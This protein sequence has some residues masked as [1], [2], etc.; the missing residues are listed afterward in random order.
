MPLPCEVLSDP[1][2]NV[3]VLVLSPGFE[4][5]R[6]AA[7]QACGVVLVWPGRGLVHELH[8]LQ[9]SVVYADPNESDHHDE[10]TLSLSCIVHALRVGVLR[11]VQLP[12]H[13]HEVGDKP[14]DVRYS[15]PNLVETPLPDRLAEDI[16]HP[17]YREGPEYHARVVVRLH[18]R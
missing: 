6:E 17:R 18:P 1:Q 5:P 14:K 9:Y 15:R 7:L 13:P 12:N 11:V 3:E 8:G 2:E 10:A 4:E 16:D